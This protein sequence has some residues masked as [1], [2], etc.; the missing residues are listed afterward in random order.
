[1]WILLVFVLL[2]FQS[3]LCGDG[4]YLCYTGSV[5]YQNTIEDC[6]HKDPSY[7]GTWYCAKVEVRRTYWR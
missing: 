3:V 2:T 4:R 7:E 5:L 1:M 6:A